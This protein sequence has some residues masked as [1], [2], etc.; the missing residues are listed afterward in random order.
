MTKR[1]VFG[2]YQPLAGVDQGEEVAARWRAISLRAGGSV[3][4]Q[5]FVIDGGQQTGIF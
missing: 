5:V 2:C 4:G 3:T 1:P